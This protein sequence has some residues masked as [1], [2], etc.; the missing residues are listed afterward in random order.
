MS[1]DSIVRGANGRAGL[2]SAFD[3]KS[4]LERQYCI[5][6][7]TSRLQPLGNLVGQGNQG[8]GAADSNPSASLAI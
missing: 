7:L 3:P 6:A 1:I 8:D 5:G 2:T 4:A